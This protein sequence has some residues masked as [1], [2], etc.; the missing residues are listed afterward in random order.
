[1]RGLLPPA[2]TSVCASP[3]STGSRTPLQVLADYYQIGD[4]R[5]R[6]L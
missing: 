6:D 2:A 1:M 5:D 3:T 4:T